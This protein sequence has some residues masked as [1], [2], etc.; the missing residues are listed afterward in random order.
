MPF[1]F[2]HPAIVLPLSRY[3]RYFSLTGLIIGSI[4]PDF[5]YII[6]MRMYGSFSHSLAGVV[7]FDIP[8]AIALTFVFH[9]I[10]RNRLLDH[11]PNGLAYRLD[12]VN[13]MAEYKKHW[14]KITSS[15]VIGIVSHLLWDDFTHVNGY[16]VLGWDILNRPFVFSGSSVAL[17]KITQHGS[18]T[19]GC[20]AVIFYFLS[21]PNNKIHK[22][23]QTTAYWPLVFVIALG[24]FLTRCSYFIHD[25]SFVVGNI[26]VAL[27]TSI[28]VALIWTPL[29][30]AVHA[31]LSK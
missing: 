21:Q 30:L 20:L 13:W 10:I 6:R 11:L 18:S 31:R 19:I 26:V 24:T 22:R 3:Q 9:C 14:F 27:I 2:A 29:L 8:I 4:A 25:N 7:Y 28:I 23:T 5:E 15:I 16:F 1:T 17:Y 12:R